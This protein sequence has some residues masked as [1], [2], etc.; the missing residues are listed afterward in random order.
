MY[1]IDGNGTI[2]KSEMVQ[3]I[4]VSRTCQAS[5]FILFSL[6]RY[7][8]VEKVNLTFCQYYLRNGDI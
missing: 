8:D 4:K 6:A 3:I 1:D 2:E 5:D 7:I